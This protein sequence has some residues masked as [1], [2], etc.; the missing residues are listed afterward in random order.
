MTNLQRK[1]DFWIQC[2][3]HD[4]EQGNA[5]NVTNCDLNNS[6]LSLN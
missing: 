5:R 1:I 2:V 4:Q 6:H 3:L